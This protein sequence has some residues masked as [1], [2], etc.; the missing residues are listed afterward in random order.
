MFSFWEKNEMSFLMQS[1]DSV[2]LNPSLGRKKSH[3]FV[4]FNRFLHKYSWPQSKSI[5][6]FHRDQKTFFSGGYYFFSSS[7]SH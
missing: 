3:V 2:E 7:K 4:R 1:R 5:L 6:F